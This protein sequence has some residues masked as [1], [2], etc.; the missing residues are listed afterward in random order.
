MKDFYENEKTNNMNKKE[1]NMYILHLDTPRIIIISSVMVGLIVLSI[2]TGMNISRQ[3]EK[4]NEIFSQENEIF[5]SLINENKKDINTYDNNII[6]HPVEKG[7]VLKDLDIDNK[8]Q[9]PQLSQSTIKDDPLKNSSIKN[10]EDSLYD[11]STTNTITSNNVKPADILTHENIES[12]LPP[13][14]KITKSKPKKSVKKIAKKHSS[15]KRKKRKKKQRVVE[16]ASKKTHKSSFATPKT[17]RS[18]YAIQVA[19]FDKKS[20]ALSEV[21]RLE[22]MRYNAYIAKGKV[23]G[24]NYYRVR[25]G[26]IFSRKK[27]TNLLDEIQYD[28]EYEE[29][30]MVKE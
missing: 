29:S 16:V 14:K 21:N 2:L 10:F 13:I 9:P 6:E 26:P 11:K 22:R 3:G 15:K 7:I 5:D 12:F 30:F 23:N 4:E 27:A 1:K 17:D 25:V 20:K 19:S 18:H 28:E 24:K 8:N